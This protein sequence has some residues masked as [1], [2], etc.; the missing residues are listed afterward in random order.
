MNSLDKAI[1][2]NNEGVRLLGVGNCSAGLQ[3]F[4]RAIVLLRQA[5]EELD[6]RTGALPAES[7][8]DGRD[9]SSAYFCVGPS[10]RNLT[11]LQNAH[12]YVYDRPLLLPTKMAISCLEEFDSVVLTLSTSVIFN[13][14]L[15]CHQHGQVTGLAVALTK[16]ANLYEFI[17]KV[18]NDNN[19]G[20]VDELE[21]HMLLCLALNNL[22]QLHY[23]S[24][25]YQKCQIYLDKLFDVVVASPY[26]L[27]DSCLNEEDVE[28]I[29]LNLVHMNPPSGACAA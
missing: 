24:C 22:A 29:M 18:L 15:A 8:E 4:Q 14:A 25:D 5:S 13:M 1:A 7:S 2:I 19:D 16:S 20:V 23:D 17:V 9:D 27:D 6:P 10:S 26:C 28:E 21:H 12:C 3:E 11:G